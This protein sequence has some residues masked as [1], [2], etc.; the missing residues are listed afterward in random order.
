M[1]KNPDE[2]LD[3]LFAAARHEQPE[4]GRGD[5]AFETR[6][7]ARIREERSSNW[8]SWAWRMSPYFAALA[9]AASAWGYLQRDS[10]P[11]PESLAASLREG[12]LPV[13]H[14]YLGADE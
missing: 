5:F 3:R 2:S 6:V 1:E 13:L 8:F 10:L 11:D 7:L 14:Y 4:V 12:G 9:L